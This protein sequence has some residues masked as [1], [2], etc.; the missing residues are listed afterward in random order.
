MIPA[1]SSSSAIFAAIAAG[2][3]AAL[4]RL[5]RTADAQHVNAITSI[6][7]S[8]QVV[9]TPLIRAAEAGDVDA[10]A[11][12]LAHPDINVNR[13]PGVPP[14][15]L[16]T[17][18]PYLCV[19]SVVALLVQDLPISVDSANP[20]RLVDNPDHSFYSWMIFLDPELKVP[21]DV[22]KLAVIQ[23]IL[24]LELFA[25]V[26][27]THVVRRLMAA[28]DEHGRPA[29]D[30]ADADVRAFLTNQLYFLGR[31]ELLLDAPPVH[32]SATS[33]VV[34]AYDHGMYAQVFEEEAEGDDNDG[35]LLDLN[36]FCNCLR[37]LAPLRATDDISDDATM[38]RWE[39][40]FEMLDTDRDDV[41]TRDEFL[42]YCDQTFGPYLKVA[43]KF[44]KSQADY[45]R[46]C[47][48]RQ[49]LDLNF[50]L[51]LV[52]SPAELPDDFAQTMSQLPLSHLSHINMAEYANL[53]VMPAADRS[54]EDIFLKERPS[55]AQV[56]DMIKQVAAALD[57]LHSHR[58]VHGDLKKLNVLRMGQQRDSNDSVMMLSDIMYVTEKGRIPVLGTQKSHDMASSP[59]HTP[60]SSMIS[61]Q[62]IT[63]S[64][65]LN[66]GDLSLW[67]LDLDKL[68]AGRVLS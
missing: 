48:H 32:V 29:I 19:D 56:I 3:T 35:Y 37:A 31:Y 42:R 16:Q 52:P 18:A 5:V 54:L 28:P 60:L 49:R 11:I 57:H 44:I 61:S 38:H 41:I 1:S 21:D 36:G 17:L 7:K 58:I 13:P 63:D 67:R 64:T 9:Y 68:T 40:E 4:Q 6:N 26:P 66:L 46:E 30:A 12:L 25:Q 51:G 65:Q 2:D 23:R 59:A 45:D 33:V 14:L 27:R 8:V 15:V 47:Y 10:V 50:V 55:E 53:V 24:D 20:S 62:S 43:I 39:A 22:S 34:L